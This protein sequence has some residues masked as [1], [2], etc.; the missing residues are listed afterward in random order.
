MLGVD[1]AYL[2]TEIGHSNFESAVP[3]IWLVPN[4]I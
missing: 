3:L 2:C 1:I 4:E